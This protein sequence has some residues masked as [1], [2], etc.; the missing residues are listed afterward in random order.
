MAQFEANGP[1][2]TEAN[3]LTMQAEASILE[4]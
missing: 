4:T 3:I 1:V 2:Q